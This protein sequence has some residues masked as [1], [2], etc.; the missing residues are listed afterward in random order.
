MTAVN[1]A[2]A[3]PVLPLPAWH[4]HF[5]GRPASQQSANHCDLDR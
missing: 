2:D 3:E 5:R 4:E 1:T